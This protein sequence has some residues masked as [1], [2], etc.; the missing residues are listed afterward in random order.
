MLKKTKTGAAVTPRSGGRRGFTLIELLVV[1]SIIATLMS[2][3]LPA[4][5]NAREAGRRTQCLNNI[6][7]VTVACLNLAS[8]SPGQHLP[9]L[10]YYPEDP[11]STGRI[12]DFYEGR[13]WVVE[14]LPFM[15]QQGTYDRWDKDI[16]WNSGTNLALASDLYIEALA[17]PNDDSAFAT[18]GGLTYVANSGFSTN[19]GG[20]VAATQTRGHTFFDSSCDW[21]SNGAIGDDE[22]DEIL[23]RTGVF[24]PN[25]ANGPFQPICKNRCT[26]VGKIYDGSSNTVMLTENINAGQTN[27]ANPSLNNC[28]F[29][30][31]V[32]GGASA[33]SDTDKASASL[34]ANTPTGQLPDTE[35]YINEKKA[36]PEGAPFPNSNHPGICVFSMCDGAARAISENID[37]YVYTQ[38]ITPHSTRL[39]TIQ[40]PNVN[41]TSEAPLSGDSF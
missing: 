1:I 29:M 19:V 34:F 25:F 28:G 21:N 18:P 2:L 36:G 17:C 30:W 38:L 35:P 31:P 23:Y 12:P 13:S 41:F 24:W 14:I 22:D 5:Q 3:I 37:E 32:G 7:N 39:R 15:D 10:S 26:N 6:R 40:T 20:A 33:P 4:I 16:P 11:N 8:G 27:W 9:A